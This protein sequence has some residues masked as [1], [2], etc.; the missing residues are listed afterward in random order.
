VASNDGYSGKERDER[1]AIPDKGRQS[2]PQYCRH[3]QDNACEQALFGVRFRSIG[4][5]HFSGRGGTLFYRERIPNDDHWAYH[6]RLAR[7]NLPLE[8]P[9]LAVP[10]ATRA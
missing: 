8:L 9:S 10:T 5:F 6:Q 2:R 4:H 7:D 1:I 3:E